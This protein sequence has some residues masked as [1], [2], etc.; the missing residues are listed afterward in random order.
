MK[1]LTG[2]KQNKE[3]KVIGLTG[4]IGSGKS[5]A[6]RILEED[7]K[8]LLLNTDR[9]AHEFMAEGGISYKLIVEYFG[10]DILDGEGRIDRAKLGKLVYQSAEKL[11]ILNSFSHPYVM[12]YVRNQIKEVKEKGSY[13]LICVE[14]ALPREAVL[15]D[16]CDEIWYVSAERQVRIERLKNSRN[17]NTEK[18]EQVLLNQLT[19][20]EYGKLSTH[21][22]H[23]NSTLENLKL[24]IESFLN[25][26]NRK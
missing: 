4:G 19:E 20:E 3:I 12:D 15:E 17:F 22:L 25:G 24:Q 1:D 7:Y 6:A 11:K 5:E 10:R 18:F 2:M 23:N 14:T 8:A 26:D 13:P 21:I 16:F 9:I